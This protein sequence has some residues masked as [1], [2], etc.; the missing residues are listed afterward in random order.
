[1]SID[2]L[3]GIFLSNCR[4][5]RGGGGEGVGFDMDVASLSLRKGHETFPY[6]VSTTLIFFLSL[7]NETKII[8]TFVCAIKTSL[9]DFFK[10]FQSVTEFCSQ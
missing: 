7:V 10:H 6:V 8:C 3:I 4:G 1:M 9:G 2:L 5:G